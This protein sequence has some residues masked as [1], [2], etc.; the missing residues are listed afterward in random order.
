MVIHSRVNKLIAALVVFIE[1]RNWDSLCQRSV[2]SFHK[3]YS[4]QYTQRF[5]R[6]GITSAT[7]PISHSPP[8]S[9]LTNF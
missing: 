1:Q 2:S 6:R 8:D 9:P 4:L 5:Y 7:L 3:S